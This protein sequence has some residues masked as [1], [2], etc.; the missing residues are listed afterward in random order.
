MSAPPES[1]TDCLPARIRANCVFL[2][3]DPDYI[4]FRPYGTIAGPVRTARPGAGPTRSR[5]LYFLLTLLVIALGLFSR[6]RTLA[7]PAAF[8]KVSGDALW[9]LMVF[10]GIAFLRP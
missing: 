8:A 10:F 1:A 4:Q 3:P 2:R 7:L 5:T 6:S 9:S